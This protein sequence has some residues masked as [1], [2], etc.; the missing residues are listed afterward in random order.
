MVHMILKKPDRAILDQHGF[1]KAITI[2]ECAIVDWHSSI[3]GIDDL[4]VEVDVVQDDNMCL[5]YKRSCQTFFLR[6]MPWRSPGE[7]EGWSWS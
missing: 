6:P 4:S 2:P 1:K 3:C 7:S 5:R